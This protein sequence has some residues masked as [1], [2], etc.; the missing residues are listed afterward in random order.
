MS[1]SK[2]KLD[3]TLVALAESLDSLGDKVEESTTED[4][5][6]SEIYG[7]NFPP[8]N[9]H[10]LSDIPYTLSEQLRESGIESIDSALQEKLEAARK[11]LEKL[12]LDIVPHFFNGNG[13]TVTPIYLS[14]FEWLKSLLFPILTWQTITEPKALPP[15]LIR[16]LRTLNTQL[17][18]IAV[19]KD[20]LMQQM[21]QIKEAHETAESL[22]T[23]LQSLKEARQEV[24]SILE[25]ALSSKGKISEIA[26]L[27]ET[28]LAQISDNKAK[29]DELVDRCD[30]AYRITTT[31]GLA[32]SFD[33]RAKDLIWSI[34]CWVAG[35]ICALAAGGW[36]G[37]LKVP[38]LYKALENGD[39]VGLQFTLTI[40]SLGG[41]VWF[42]WLAT[43]QI[44]QRFKLTEDYAYKASVAKAYEGYR[45]EAARIDEAFEARL[46]NSALQRVEEAPLRLVDLENHGSPWHEFVCSDAFMAALRLIP[47]FKDKYI[48]MCKPDKEVELEVEETAEEVESEDKK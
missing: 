10:D 16:R 11:K 41:P 7:W 32:A 8:L 3:E 13:T 24:K 39:Y 43:K 1:K 44:G 35:L 5:T 9:R 36:I 26:E 31:T 14:T 19:D 38:M 6:I 25:Y 46:F 27:S 48:S 30:D 29:T 17:D 37:S 34:R 42:A 33:K 21:T 2:D 23:D 22:P 40:F 15:H 4:R 45:K 18:G 20:K 12:E 47:G 28:N